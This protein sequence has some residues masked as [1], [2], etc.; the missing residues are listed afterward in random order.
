MF[1][2]NMPLFRCF[3][4]KM[5]TQY[6]YGTYST[7]ASNSAE[8]KAQISPIWETI[9]LQDYRLRQ[10]VYHSDVGLRNLRY[11]LFYSLLTFF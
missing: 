4:I 3:S 8:R 10:A 6:E 5:S 7:Y 9:D 2:S 1:V 11:V